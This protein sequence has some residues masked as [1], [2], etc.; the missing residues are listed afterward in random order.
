MIKSIIDQITQALSDHF[1]IEATHPPKLFWPDDI[2]QGTYRCAQPQLQPDSMDSLSVAEYQGG[3]YFGHGGYTLWV[4]HMS[5]EQAGG[6][7]RLELQREDGSGSLAKETLWMQVH[8][9]A[10]FSL[11]DAQERVNRYEWIPSEQ[12]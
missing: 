12:A 11:A 9:P 8:G 7:I 5:Q 1:D 10:A 4:K 6:P 3:P 2:R